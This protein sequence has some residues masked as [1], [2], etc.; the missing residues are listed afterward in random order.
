MQMS[1][2]GVGGVADEQWR[3][4]AYGLWSNS[5]YGSGRGVLMS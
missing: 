4:E 5:S 1:L 3:G 2:E